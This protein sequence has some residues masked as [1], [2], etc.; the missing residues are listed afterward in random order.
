[1]SR[2]RTLLAWALLAATVQAVTAGCINGAV[3]PAEVADEPVEVLR[4][5]GLQ[6]RGAAAGRQGRVAR[7][8]KRRALTA[9]VARSSR[10]EG[11]KRPD[12]VPKSRVELTPESDNQRTRNIR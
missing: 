3:G 8:R 9:E 11:T 7:W 5:R 1:M 12:R 4:A 10:I 6:G 2:P